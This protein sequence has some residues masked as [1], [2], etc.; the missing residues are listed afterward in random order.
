MSLRTNLSAIVAFVA[1]LSLGGAAVFTM[2]SQR[3][4]SAV[5]EGLHA[6]RT[7]QRLEID[8]LAHAHLRGATDRSNLEAKL[9]QDL[10]ESE[11]YI[12]NPAER[13]A[14]QR[15]QTELA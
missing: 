4:T 14:F 7:L 1:V 12:G 3:T 11:R 5:V 15:V 13:S 10:R 8:L 6:I 2:Y 9:H